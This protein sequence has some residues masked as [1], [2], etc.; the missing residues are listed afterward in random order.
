MEQLRDR[1]VQAPKD[2][3]RAR[4]GMII[5]STNRTVEKELVAAYPAGVGVHIARV[6]WKGV[7][8]EDLRVSVAAAAQTLADAACKVIVFN[9]TASS[10]EHG[11]EENDR[12]LEAIGRSGA[13]PATTATAIMD[14]VGALGVRSIALLT[15]Y[16]REVTRR[17][18][19]FFEDAL[20]EVVRSVYTAANR[21]SD[22]CFLPSQHWLEELTHAPAAGVDAHL[23]S[24][25]NLACLDIIDAAE[26][27]LGRPVLTSNQC[28]LWATLRHA[29]IV[30]PVSGIGQ[31]GR[32]PLAK[33]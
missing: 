11:A 16:T 3:A 30:D 8:P 19:A 13:K 7:A 9:C 32:L 12:L 33:H 1:E 31:L 20:I 21:S 10:M 27:R 22:Y 29:G 4:I 15:P 5:P 2:S 26:E 6:P 23:L 28:V 18:R 24:C 14:G 17:Q 25:A